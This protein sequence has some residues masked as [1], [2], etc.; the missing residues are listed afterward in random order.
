MDAAATQS[1]PDISPS[2]DEINMPEYY[3]DGGIPVVKPT[4]EQFKDFRRF[5]NKID[6]L[7][8]EAG[9]VKVIPPREWLESLS[10]ITKKMTDS[11]RLDSAIKQ[12]FTGTGGTF[13][14]LNMG[15]R[16]RLS[17]ADWKAMCES[18]KH[19]PPS[20]GTAS[21]RRQESSRT[22]KRMRVES[23]GKLDDCSPEV[24]A[25]A[26]TTATE[27]HDAVDLDVSPTSEKERIPSDLIPSK[28]YFPDSPDYINELERSYWKNLTFI[29]PW[30]GADIAGTFFD[31]Q[32]QE[33]N[34]GKLDSLLSNL[35]R[36]VPGVNTP[37]LYFGMWKATFSWHLEVCLM[38]FT[39]YS[40]DKFCVSTGYGFI[41]DQLHPF[42]STETVVRH[43]SRAQGSL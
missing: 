30:Y 18:E 15:C 9:L 6:P 27:N 34:I 40:I 4:L 2:N 31:D 10:P 28:G 32:V 29:E 22:V 14:Q 21:G 39:V 13:T 37:Y 38:L 33:W 5:I 43:S 12:H 3:M 17:L 19:R 11:I 20:F 25:P 1:L 23:T 26:V 36:P 42:R 41:F 16:K 7:G 24:C 35:K 8:A